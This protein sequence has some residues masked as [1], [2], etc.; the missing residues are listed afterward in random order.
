MKIKAKGLCQRHY[1]KLRRRGDPLA[2]DST[3]G[4][5]KHGFAV[6]KN[7][8]V[9]SEYTAWVNMKVRCYDEKHWAY[10]YYGGRGITVCDDWLGENGFANFI[11]DVGK[12]PKSEK[13]L[14]LDRIDCNKGYC[15]ENCRW[16]DYHTQ[17]VNQRR[18]YI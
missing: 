14:T 3:G 15:K 17:R 12:K 7:G 2:E 16:T 10:K 9:S 5:T 13:K 6:R 8:K 4:I 11:K 1:D 18:M